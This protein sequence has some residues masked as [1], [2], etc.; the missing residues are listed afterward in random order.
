MA[1]LPIHSN[2]FEFIIQRALAL[3]IYGDLRAVC[4]N[5]DRATPNRSLDSLIG[6]ASEEPP[7]THLPPQQRRSRKSEKHRRDLKSRRG[8][9][10]LSRNLGGLLVGQP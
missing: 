8:P 9:A 2:L 1:K 7:L 4:A 3:R 6:Q 5:M 10:A